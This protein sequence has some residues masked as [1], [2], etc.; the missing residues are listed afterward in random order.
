MLEPNRR[1]KVAVFACVGV[2]QQDRI[3]SRS[4]ASVGVDKFRQ[5]RCIGHFGFFMWVQSVSHEVS[6][7]ITVARFK[8]YV[9]SVDIQS[10]L[11]RAMKGFPTELCDDHSLIEFWMLC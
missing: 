4:G 10:K 1:H 9:L 6:H 11:P 7:K 3:E 8:C 5:T 2:E